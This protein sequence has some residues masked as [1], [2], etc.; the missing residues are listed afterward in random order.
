MVRISRRHIFRLLFGAVPAPT[1]VETAAVLPF[2]RVHTDELAS[3]FAEP[4]NQ[5]KPRVYWWWLN[6]LVSKEGITRDLEEFKAKGIGGVLLFAAGGGNPM[7]AGPSFLGPEWRELFKHALRE[8]DRLSIEIS[9]NLC[10]GWDMGGPWITPEHGLKKV[11]QSEVSL[12]GP[13]KFSGKLPQ[14]GDEGVNYWDVTVQ[15][16]PLSSGKAPIHLREHAP[17]EE[18][19]ADEGEQ[20]HPRGHGYGHGQRHPGAGGV[21]P[22]SEHGSRRP[23]PSR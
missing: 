13:Q 14:P 23:A 8:A 19:V 15:A 2:G 18:R 7:P 20:H 1:L 11:V 12:R 5:A 16:F 22:S 10:G 9:V 17:G 21:S 3:G 6:N 4:P